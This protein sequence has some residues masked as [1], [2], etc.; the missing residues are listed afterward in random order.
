MTPNITALAG[1]LP[2]AGSL[3]L[4]AHV[5]WRRRS[6]RRTEPPPHRAATTR[7]QIQMPKEPASARPDKAPPPPRICRDCRSP[8]PPEQLLC[9][10]CR[11]RAGPSQGGRILL[12]W[13]LFLAMMAAILGAGYLLA[14]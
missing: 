3:S 10:A 2:A 6:R 12:H 13:V 1:L 8:I 11:D 5:L 4:I 7:S 9:P 14:R